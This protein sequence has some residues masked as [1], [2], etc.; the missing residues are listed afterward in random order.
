[1]NDPAS[2]RPVEIAAPPAFRRLSSNRF[3]ENIGGGV[4]DFMPGMILEHRP[5]RTV[6]DADVVLMGTFI[7]NQVPIHLDHEF[8]RS[9]QWGQPLVCSLIT[10]CLIGGMST[11]FTSGLTVAN[12]EWRHITLP[13]PVFVGDTLHAES[14]ILSARLSGSRPH[15]GVITCATRGF[16]QTGDCVLRYER[17]FLVPADPGAVRAAADY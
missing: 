14:E 17:S 3:R 6:T 2:A 16:K 1:M 8:A 7:G 13:A 4:T 9:S 5:A 11:R 10:L 15:L 12:L